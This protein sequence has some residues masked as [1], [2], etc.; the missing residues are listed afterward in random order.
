MATML[1]ICLEKHFVLIIS[2]IL[3]FWVM[4]AIVC[5]EIAEASRCSD[6]EVGKYTCGYADGSSTGF[7]E[8]EVLQ[9]LAS[10][11][12]A[13]EWT[14]VSVC[15]SGLVCHIGRNGDTYTCE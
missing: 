12:G 7:S 13:L 10:E 2:A 14:V 1:T 11:C 9:C 8:D 4:T 3:A 15:D 6:S 5:E